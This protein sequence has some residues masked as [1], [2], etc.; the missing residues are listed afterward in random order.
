MIAASK[1]ESMKN[2]F[3]YMEQIQKMQLDFKCGMF[4]KFIDGE[5]IWYMPK[6]L[7]FLDRATM[8]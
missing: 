2:A 3:L 6:K 7:M 5:F 8:Q 1:K 4:P